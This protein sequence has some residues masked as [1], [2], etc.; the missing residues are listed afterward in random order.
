M[1]KIL[2][3]GGGVAGLSAGIYARLNGHEAIVC[4]KHFVAG[5]NLTGWN[6]GGYH[7]D[8]CIH[9]LTG[10]NPASSHYKMW[11]ELGA[12]GDGIEIVQE[13]SLFSCDKDGKRVMLPPSLAGLEKQMLDHSKND[14]REI[15]RF[16]RAVDFLQG[17]DNIAGKKCD[18][19]MTFGR[20]VKGVGPL[21]RYY[22]RTTGE[23]AALFNSP[24]LRTFIT[25]FWGD[26][27]G[28]LALIYVFA[29]F[30]GKNG[31]LPRGGSVKMA[32]RMVE[33]FKKLGGELRL[34][35]EA[36]KVNLDGGVARSVTFAD[37]SEETADFVILTTD[38]AM[39]FGK[40]IDCPMP[41]NLKKLYD[42]P[43]MLRYSA[44]H[45]AFGCDTPTLPFEGDLIFDV[46]EEFI[47]VLKTK[48]VILRGFSHE[49]NFSPEGKS[50][51][52]TLT[53][54]FEEDSKEFIR[55]KNEDPEAY[56]ARKKKI[57]EIFKTLIEEHCESL[58]GKLELIDVWTPASYRKFVSSDIGSFMS[59][60]MPKKY[61]PVALSGEIK[62]LRNVVLATQWQQSP[63]GLPIAAGQGKNAIKI[64]EGKALKNKSK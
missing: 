1:A 26:D 12:L 35:C 36:V 45:C 39:T 15:K 29:T 23:L 34:S 46:P 16:I 28:A 57:A 51:I 4:E 8:N 50:L 43:K 55:L 54:S 31:A 13:G 58:K 32:E 10:T 2:I 42:D 52:Q 30:C 20:L 63:G 27:F 60:A 40:I 53:F 59:F 37:G 56:K 19:G 11:V 44:Y 48:Q 62:E 7:I 49:S 25:G 24:A 17:A 22:N 61:M 47:D 21:L 5:G 3:I 38:P 14:E 6:R 64:I 33:R 18:E 41:S 9:W